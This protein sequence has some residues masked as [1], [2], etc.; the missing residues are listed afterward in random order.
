M[1]FGGININQ[2]DIIGIMPN[3]LGM[4][5]GMEGSMGMIPNIG[6]NVMNPDIF[7]SIW[8]ISNNNLIEWILI[9]ENEEDKSLIIIRIDNK[10]L[11]KEAIGKYYLKSGRKDSRRFFFNNKELFG[12][13]T[14]SQ[15]GLTNLSKIFVKSG[16]YFVYDNEGWNLIFENKEDKKSLIIK[17]NEQRSVKEAI[18]I[19][20]LKSGRKYTCKFFLNNK[21]LELEN[22]GK[23]KIYQLDHFKNV[24]ISKILVEVSKD[25]SNEWNLIFED[26]EDKHSI[27]VR[28]NPEKLIK[29]AISIYYLISGKKDICKFIFNNKEL[30]DEMKVCQS[31]LQDC[32]W[33]YV[34]TKS[35]GKGPIVGDISSNYSINFQLNNFNPAYY[36]TQINELRKQLIT[37]K[38]KNISLMN[39]NAKYNEIINHLNSNQILLN[40][41]ISILE[42][43][44]NKK[45]M[46]LQNYLNNMKNFNNNNINN[47]NINDLVT[48]INPGEKI[49]TVNFVSHG[50]QDI[51]NYSIPCKNT[52]LF[53]RLE[54]KLNKDFP[55][56]K[57]HETF[58]VVNT[59]RIKR[60]QTLEENKIKSNDIINIF[61][62]D[63]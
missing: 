9:F 33:I 27:I 28:I 5:P 21:E 31:G 35:G 60:F 1:Q 2:L 13:M 54:E 42:N 14:I 23:M 6:N 63:A 4:M 17:I 24:I 29:D 18:S 30:F 7:P 43:A 22:I 19:Y 34:F 10:K 39:E 40:N 26:N 37:E 16:N 46:E 20:Y 50:F 57:N 58:F 38:T 36:E 62:I 59:R 8:N 49:I 53:I 3:G 45:N 41:K 12:E 32:S 52:N 55:Q 47:Y 61:T 15:H 56:L 44:L 51:A 25:D 11:V 48:S